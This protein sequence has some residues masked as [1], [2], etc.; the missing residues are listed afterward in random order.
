MTRY[1][2][3]QV[4]I[5]E[6]P[7]DRPGEYIARSWR[8]TNQLDPSPIAWRFRTEREAHAFTRAAWPGLVL[9]QGRGADPDPTIIAVYT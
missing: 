5:Y 3:I 4:V 2:L 1:A 9:L 8:V 7:R 6:S